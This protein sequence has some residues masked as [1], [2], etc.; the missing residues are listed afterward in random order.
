MGDVGFDTESLHPRPGAPWWAAERWAATAAHRSPRRAAAGALFAGC[1]L[2]CLLVATALAG[3]GSRGASGSGA[4]PGPSP[5]ER[6]APLLARATPL[7]SRPEI[8]LL[9]DAVQIDSAR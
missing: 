4:G 5:A 8:V 3:C 6:A 2:L 1:C 7:P 9:A